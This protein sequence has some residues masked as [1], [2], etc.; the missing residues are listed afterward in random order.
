MTSNEPYDQTTDPAPKREVKYPQIEVQL[1]GEDG[2]AFGILGRMNKALRRGGCSQAE[3]DQF[4]NEAMSG[5][6]SELLRTC[7]RWVTVK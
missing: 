1:T 6:Y 7:T 5:D 3:I 4:Q 2:N